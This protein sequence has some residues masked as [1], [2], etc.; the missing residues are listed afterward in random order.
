[1]QTPVLISWT[2][3]RKMMILS[4]K[5]VRMSAEAQVKCGLL[6]VLAIRELLQRS[7]TDPLTRQHLI[8]IHNQ[9]RYA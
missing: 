6:I 8:F 7:E 3:M 4:L 9:G 2:L 1:M 5:T